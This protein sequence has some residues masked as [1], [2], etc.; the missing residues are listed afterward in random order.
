VSNAIWKT[1]KRIQIL[2]EIEEE[3]TSDSDLEFFLTPPH[4]PK[5]VIHKSVE[6][7][8]RCIEECNKQKI[9]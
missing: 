4:N 6:Y 9:A 1:L 2:E 8:Y 5:E 3:E 7:D